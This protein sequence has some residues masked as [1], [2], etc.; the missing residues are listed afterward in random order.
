MNKVYLGII[1]VL[2]CTCLAGGQ[3]GKTEKNV[4][5]GDRSVVLSS[6]TSIDAEL[7]KTLDVRQLEIG[8]EV[9]LKTRQS[10]K[11]NGEV[12]VPKGT[13]LIGRV[14]DLKRKTKES[15]ES[16]VGIIFDRLQGKELSM[17]LNATL[18]SIT[19]VAAA[20]SVDDSLMTDVSGSSSTTASSSRP[21]SGGGLLG[22]VTNTVGGVVNTT[23]QTVG[24]VTNT[25]GQ[26][27]GST[28]GSLGRALNGIRIQSETSASAGSSATLSS[29]NHNVRVE[30]GATFHLR[31][32]N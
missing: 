29:P 3:T 23:T 17:P 4:P 22:G 31:V 13:K 25:A 9:I 1:T 30:K 21:A 7:Q 6:G 27:V 14:T 12:V 24:T 15:A 20:A 5:A 16:R 18:V 19:N 32:A 28:T 10:I 26:T 11:Q 2:V 8:D